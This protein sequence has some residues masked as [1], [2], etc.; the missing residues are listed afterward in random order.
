MADEIPWRFPPP[1]LETRRNPAT[2]L[3][4]PVMRPVFVECGK[5]VHIRGRLVQC[6]RRAG[7]PVRINYAHSNGYVEWAFE[8]EDEA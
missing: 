2:G 1:L 4:E 8:E 6:I 7:H 5:R 3:V